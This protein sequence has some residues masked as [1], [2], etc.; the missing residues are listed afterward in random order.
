MEIGKMKRFLWDRV[1]K[2]SGKEMEIKLG[3][4]RWLEEKKTF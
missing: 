3:F 2:T 1:V 4:E